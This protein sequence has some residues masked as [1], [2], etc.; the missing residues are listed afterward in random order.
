VTLLG[1]RV[2]LARDI[3]AVAGAAQDARFSIEKRVLQK[4][5]EVAADALGWGQ[6]LDEVHHSDDQWGLLGTSAGYQVLARAHV[7]GGSIPELDHARALL[8]GDVSDITALHPAVQTKAAPPKSDLAN[9]VRL[10]AIA[11]ALSA[12]QPGGSA[13]L[14]HPPLV[15]HILSLAHH[16][17]CW[18]PR[19]AQP[20]GKN[21]DGHAVTTAYVLH[22]IRR[23]ETDRAQFRPVRAWLARQL[24][25]DATLR[26]R[27]DYLALIGLALT[28]PSADT[29]D[30]SDV[31]QAIDRC[32]E[33]LLAWRKRERNLVLNRPLFEGYQLGTST[34]Y[35]IFNPEIMAA[36]FFLRSD[37]PRPAR[38]FV[39]LVTHEVSRNVQSNAGFQGQLGMIP[40]VDQEWASRLLHEFA[41]IYNDKTRRPLLLPGRLTSPLVRWGLVVAAVAVLTGVLIA[42][43]VDFKTGVLVFVAGAI[44][45]VV[46]VIVGERGDD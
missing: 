39:A 41:G 44:L 2:W 20:D 27:P 16:G 9:I 46:L 25:N 26:A 17:Q 30:H 19:S 37:N 6:Y 21:L 33:E 36:L 7:E 3:K 28:A 11:E 35:L 8:P 14:A 38:R 18:N 23:Y 10:A 12:D 29:A 40:T 42:A 22:A 13:G 15:D 31:R 5:V 32:R 24:L 43:G 1:D 34:D 4:K 45:A